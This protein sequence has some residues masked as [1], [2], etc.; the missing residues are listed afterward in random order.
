MGGRRTRTARQD[1]R[2]YFAEAH[3]ECDEMHPIDAKVGQI[4]AV[5]EVEDR[6]R[7]SAR[8]LDELIADPKIPRILVGRLHNSWLV[9]EATLN[10][11]HSVQA[12]AYY[13]L[14]FHDGLVAGRAE[15]IRDVA[16]ASPAHKQE[17]ERIRI[18][19][20]RSELPDRLLARVLLDLAA[21]TL[22][23]EDGD[24]ARAAA[25]SGTKKRAP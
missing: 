8:R 21:A 19:V 6:R 25:P 3:A 11:L 13:N 14:G 1:E 20:S 15:V 23:T 17:L 12:A 9:L 16:C 10:E 4:P 24:Q 7:A 18:E 5:R 2:D 22:R